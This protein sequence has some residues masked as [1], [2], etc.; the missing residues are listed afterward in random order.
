VTNQILGKDYFVLRLKEGL[1]D[2]GRTLWF[3]AVTKNDLSSRM[4][5]LEGTLSRKERKVS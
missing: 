3:E 2:P 5:F 1:G 4:N